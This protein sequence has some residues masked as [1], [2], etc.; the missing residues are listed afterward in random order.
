[1]KLVKFL[2]DGVKNGKIKS[3]LP[4]KKNAQ[5][6]MDRLADEDLSYVPEREFPTEGFSVL[7]ILPAG[8]DVPATKLGSFQYK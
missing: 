8:S 1:M 4:L 6:M 2:S 5:M 3:V 7:A